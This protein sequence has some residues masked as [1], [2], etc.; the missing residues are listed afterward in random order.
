[1]NEYKDTADETEIYLVD[2]LQKNNGARNKDIYIVPLLIAN[3]TIFSLLLL[4]YSKL[5]IFNICVY[6]LNLVYIALFIVNVYMV[7][8]KFSCRADELSR[9]TKYIFKNI[10]NTESYG[11]VKTNF[12]AAF[13]IMGV[14]CFIVVSFAVSYHNLSNY[15]MI[16]IGNKLTVLTMY[17]VTLLLTAL[18]LYHVV[19]IILCIKKYLTNL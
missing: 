4:F 8:N 11:G 5:F 6:I 2:F 16:F 17:V 10:K 13:S 15:G 18:P 1:M 7:F 9:L 19:I 3:F 12:L 14:I